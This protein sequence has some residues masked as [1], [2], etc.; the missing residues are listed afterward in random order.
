[1][2][3]WCEC[4]LIFGFILLS[5][6]WKI[7]IGFWFVFFCIWLNVLYIICFVVDFLLLIIKEFMNFVII[8]LLNLVLGRMFCFFV[9]CCLD[10]GLFIWVVWCCIWI[11]VVCDYW[12]FGYLKFCVRYGIEC[13]VNFWCDCFGL[14]WWNVFE[15][16]DFC[17]GCK[18]LF[19][20]CLLVLFL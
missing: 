6:L 3:I 7:L 12:Y 14:K 15:D 17:W 13:L 19:C 2:F 16:C 20:D 11:D 10:M 18:W 4:I 9:L 1:M 8:M 5:V